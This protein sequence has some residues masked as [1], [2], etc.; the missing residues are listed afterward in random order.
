M[1]HDVLTW[2]AIGFG[3]GGSPVLPG[4]LGAL[5]GV[6]LACLVLRTPRWVQ[7]CVA[8]AAVLVALGCCH[9]AIGT[10]GGTDD[11]RIV[12]DEFLVFPVAIVGHGFARRPLV[13]GG[14]FLASRVLDW[15]KPPPVAGAGRIGGGAGVVLDDLLAN[16]YV[17][18]L[19][20]AVHAV[21]RRR[22]SGEDS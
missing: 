22:R 15:T 21:T 13:L 7:F 3:L 17:W 6:A 2:I 5:P 8:A 11:R 9:V 20:G 16:A 19:L 1:L 14:A 4:T 12:A 18:L 10:L